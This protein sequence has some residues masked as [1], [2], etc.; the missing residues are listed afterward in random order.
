MVGALSRLPERN[1]LIMHDIC[2]RMGHF[3]QEVQKPLYSAWPPP[4]I[5]YPIIVVCVVKI[6]RSKPARYHIQLWNLCQ[7]FVVPVAALQW[8]HL[9][10]TGIYWTYITLPGP[11]NRNTVKVCHVHNL[12]TQCLSLCYSNVSLPVHHLRAVRPE[13]CTTPINYCLVRCHPRS[14][15]KVKTH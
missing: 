3:Q 15:L 6:S 8:G 13:R 4:N 5:K 10:V 7:C 2:N 11:S 12:C 1:Q 14:G 9:S